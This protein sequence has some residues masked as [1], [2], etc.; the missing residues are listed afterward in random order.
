MPPGDLQASAGS[1][2]PATDYYF[3]DLVFG[4][5]F[6]TTLTYI[7]YSTVQVTC[8]TRFYSG[9]V[10]GQALVVPFS[11]AGSV[12]TRTDVLPPGHSFHDPAPGGAVASVAIPT[13]S[14][15][16]AQASCS[17]PI[18][19]SLLYRYYTSPTVVSGELAVNPETVGA[20]KFVTF[21]QSA[22][23]STGVAYANPSSTQSAVMSVTAVSSAG[24]KLGTNSMTVAP[25]QQGIFNAAP[26]LGLNTFTGWLVITSTR[27]IISLS[28]NA[29]AFPSLSSMPPGDLPAST[30]L[31]IQ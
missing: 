19:A 22:T 17:G 7:N 21:A 13:S 16:W 29:E 10:I 24:A 31:V 14:S 3:S 1:G 26:F 23:S 30:V 5:G 4:N 20:T 11:E 2:G 15:G 8:T 6:Q 25:L 28:I 9:S 12:S 18:Q 27:P